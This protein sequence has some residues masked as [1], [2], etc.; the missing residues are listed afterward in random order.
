MENKNW[1]SFLTNKL[2]SQISLETASTVQTWAF[3]LVS[4]LALGMGFQAVSQPSGEAFLSNTKILFLILSHIFILF[5]FYFPAI[6][7]KGDHPVARLLGVRNLTSLVLNALTL[8]F[9]AVVF[10]MLSFQVMKAVEQSQTSSFFNLVAW[11]NFA[12]SAVYLAGGI[13]YFAS[14]FFFPQVMIRMIEKGAKVSYVFLGLHAVLAVLLGLGYTEAVGLGSQT[15]FEQFRIA[16]VFQLALGCFLFFVG[17]VLKESA[18][19]GLANLEFEVASGRLERS[20]DILTRFKEAFVS[21]R[22]AAWIKQLSHRVA[23]LAHEIATYTHESLTAV[24]QGK[25]SEMDLRKVEERYKKADQGYRRLE[26]DNQR[27][28]LC[29]SFFDLTEAERE[30]VETL[31]DQFSRQVRNA[32]LE[33]ATVRKRID[34]KL[35]ALK[36]EMPS[37]PPAP[38]EPQ[39][40]ANR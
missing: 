34:E 22:L 30:H 1:L 36:N 3:A 23:S 15:F 25:P 35:T 29:A 37:L 9:L 7:E 2:R 21:R 20:E 16:G 32:K 18:V 12:V 24:S 27:F 40:P 17:N 28:L 14:L 10:S 39:I 26:K 5:C 13:F 19:P 38:A 4:V 11:V 6:L 8:A 31:K 33:L